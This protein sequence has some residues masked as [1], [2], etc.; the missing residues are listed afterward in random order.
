MYTHVHTYDY[1]DV[2]MY[3]ISEVEVLDSGFE[4]VQACSLGCCTEGS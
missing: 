1:V 2:Y 3:M 4:G